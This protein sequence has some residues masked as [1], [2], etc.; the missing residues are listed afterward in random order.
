GDKAALDEATEGVLHY[1]PVLRERIDVPAGNLSGGEQQM[2]VL[3]QALMGRPKLMMIDELSLGLAPV[4]VEQLL[5]TVKQLAADGMTIL[6]VEQS[7]NIALTIAERA[8]FMEKGEIRFAGKTKDL[9][10]RPDVLRS[11][12]LEGAASTV[13][14]KAAVRR[15]RSVSTNGGRR[16]PVL[17]VDGVTKSFGGVRANTDISLT[18]HEGEI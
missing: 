16:V 9:L 8:V 17:E 2:L 15:R 12:F 10:A 4:V 11:V 13:S 6:L 1:F 14:K 7:V 3:G 18:L 5:E